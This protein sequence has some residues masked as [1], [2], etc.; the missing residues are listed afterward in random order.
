MLNV[1]IITDSAAYLPPREQLAALNLQILPMSITI[2]GR[3]W[4]DTS[5]QNPR[6]LL[7]AIRTSSRPPV[8]TAPTTADYSR[9][10]QSA[11]G[12]FDGVISIHASR[13]HSNS[14]ANALQ[15]LDRFGGS[16]PIT[17]IDSR[18]ISVGQGLIVE[19]ALHAIPDHESFDSLVRAVRGIVARTFSVYYVESAEMLLHNGIISA[20]HTVLA[21]MLDVKPLLTMDEGRMVLIGKARTKAQVADQLAEFASGFNGIDAGVIIQSDGGARNE[22][23]RMLLNRLTNLVPNVTFSVSGFSPTLA[24]LIGARTGGLAILSKDGGLS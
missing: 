15:A 3:T 22:I 14:Y 12:H 11:L 23:T 18:S 10:F 4:L 21:A 13:H 5:D 17:L 16:S 7:E 24:S 8:V 9:H 6:E 20:D 2:N 1:L 19:A